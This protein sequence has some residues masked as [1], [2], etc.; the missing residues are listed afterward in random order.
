[1]RSLVHAVGSELGVPS[2]KVDAIDIDQMVESAIAKEKDKNNPE[3]A[4]DNDQLINVIIEN[5]LESANTPLLNHSPQRDPTPPPRE[6]SPPPPP[7]E[8]TPPPPPREPTPPPPTPPPSPPKEP[9]PPPPRKPTPPPREPTP[10]PREPTPQPNAQ[11]T[12]NEP[13]L[14]QLILQGLFTVFGK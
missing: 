7:R 13:P 8:P 6:A 14:I 2:E 4:T 3:P 5:R 1:M 9:T 10:P 12:I 11:L